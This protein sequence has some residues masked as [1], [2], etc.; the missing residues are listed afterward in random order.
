[1]SLWMLIRQW[2]LDNMSPMNTLVGGCALMCFP[3]WLPHISLPDYPAHQ[4]SLSSNLGA[5][6]PLNHGPHASPH[7][8]MPL[9]FTRRPLRTACT[10]A[11][12]PPGGP[13]ASPSTPPCPC[14]TQPPMRS[15]CWQRRALRC[16]TLRAPPVGASGPWRFAACGLCPRHTPWSWRALWAWGAHGWQWQACPAR[17]QAVTSYRCVGEVVVMLGW[18]GP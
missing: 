10:F 17:A 8:P 13:S 14:Q 12:Q 18:D 11:L 16:Q 7:T 2:L 5:C 9:S 6:A 1:M 4:T 3:L 15:P